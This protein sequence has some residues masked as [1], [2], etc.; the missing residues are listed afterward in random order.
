MALRRPFTLQYAREGTP[1][2][3]WT[4]PEFIRV[5]YVITAVWA[6]AF[7]VMV[8]ADLAMLYM[9]NV[10]MRVGI[11]ITIAAIYGAFKFA[12]WYPKRKS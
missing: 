9:P 7:A 2:E 5:N 4:T 3:T 1:K 11:W 10:P 8:A 12:A 6:A